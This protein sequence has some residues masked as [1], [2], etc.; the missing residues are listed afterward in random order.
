TNRK[1][2]KMSIIEGE[3]NALLEVEAIQMVGNM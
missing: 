1:Y 3:T 2:V